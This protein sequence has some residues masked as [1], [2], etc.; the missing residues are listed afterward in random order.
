MPLQEASQQAMW[1]ATS[2]CTTTTVMECLLMEGLCSGSPAAKQPAAQ[3][4]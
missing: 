3:R 4:P 1:K 2:T